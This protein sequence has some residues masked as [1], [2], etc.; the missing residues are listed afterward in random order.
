MSHAVAQP[1][2]HDPPVVDPSTVGKHPSEVFGFQPPAL[3]VRGLCGLGNLTLRSGLPLLRFQPEALLRAAER[4]T[5]LSDWGDGF[6]HELFERLLHSARTDAKLNFVG[7][8]TMTR[9]LVRVLGSW[10]HLVDHRK[11]FPHLLDKPVENPIIVVGMPRSGTTMMQHLLAAHPDA[12]FIPM[13]MAMRPLPSPTLAEWE[14]GGRPAERNNAIT[15]MHVINALSPDMERIHPYQVDHPVECTHLV[16]PSFY[17]N[18]FGGWPV[19]SYLEDSVDVDAAPSY[20]VYRE[21]LQFMQATLPGTHWLLKSP[22]HFLALEDLLESLPEARVVMLHRDPAN[23]FPSLNCMMAAHH[24]VMTDEPD[25]QRMSNMLV[26]LFHKGAMDYVALR[27]RYRDRL[28]DVR[29]P[30]LIAD[31]VGVA[32]QVAAHG[33]VRWDDEVEAAHAAYVDRRKVVR[34]ARYEYPQRQYGLTPE[35]LR[36][37]FREYLDTVGLETP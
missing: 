17:S 12:M 32:R 19:Y 23:V 9:Y 35:S 10:L 14:A 33:N 21:Y 6:G 13:W 8:Y 1:V 18:Q 37:H 24:V 3:W 27:D 26:R 36:A 7:R 5:G 34:A 31:P 15:S 16:A 29:F 20:R 22:G 30:E 25:G 2:E 28:L 11:R 4:K